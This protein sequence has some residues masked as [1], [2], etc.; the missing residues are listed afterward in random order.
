MVNPTEIPASVNR[1]MTI[2][3]AIKKLLEDY[4]KLPAGEGA[5]IAEELETLHLDGG[6][7]LFH[8]GD[9]TDA[10]YLLVRGRLQIWIDAATPIYIGEVLPGESVGH[11]YPQVTNSITKS[12]LVL[13]SSRLHQRYCFGKIFLHCLKIIC[14]FFFFFFLKGRLVFLFFVFFFFLCVGV[15]GWGGGGGGDKEPAK[16]V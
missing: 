12:A 3:D 1:E 11:V 8:Q 13:W 2:D 4:F 14:C 7:P 10:M 6:Q 9:D 15:V 5:A 16:K